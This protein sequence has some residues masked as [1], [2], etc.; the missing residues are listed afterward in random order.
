TGLGSLSPPPAR[1]AALVARLASLNRSGRPQNGRLVFPGPGKSHDS[2]LKTRFWP[3]HFHRGPC[4]AARSSND[5]TRKR[6]LS[7]AA[8]RVRYSSS[9]P[10]SPLSN[11]LLPSGEHCMPSNN[12]HSIWLASSPSHASTTPG[13]H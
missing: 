2:K 6:Q 12:S 8:A 13:P 4:V 5:Q 3:P 10:R 1:G 9:T 11:C 7:E